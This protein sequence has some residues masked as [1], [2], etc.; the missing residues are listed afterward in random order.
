MGEPNPLIG[1]LNH[2]WACVFHRDLGILLLEK[3]AVQLDLYKDI[4]RG[5]AEDGRG[6]AYGGKTIISR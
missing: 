4:C 3:K 1:G 6:S 2:V 5:F